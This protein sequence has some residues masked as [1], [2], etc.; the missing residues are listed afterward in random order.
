MV[1]P[2]R[3]AMKNPELFHIMSARFPLFATLLFIP[4]LSVAQTPQ[5]II[6]KAEDTLRG[7][8]S[9]GTFE[10]TVVTPEF[11]R[12]LKMESW[13][14]GE[15]KSL[16]VIEAPKKEEGNKWL[17]IGN[18]MWNYLKS[19]ETTIKIPPSMML[20]SWNGSDFTNDDLVRES[21]MS[22]DYDAEIVDEEETAG[23][24]CWKFRLLPKPE[25]AV[26]WGK[27]YVWVRQKDILP[28][29]VEYYDEKGVLVR[30]IVYD[31]VKTTGGRTIPTTWTMYN[32]VKEG[33]RT[34]FVILDIAFDIA[35][36][37]RVFSFREL[38]RGN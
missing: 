26:V 20:Q 28:S 18:E 11:T 38:E 17:K 33:H 25:A 37:D 22:E 8:T 4:A 29:V 9:R 34:E 15:K 19:T 7:K 5:E 13:W 14:V 16:I 3:D 24:R 30:Y 36:P 1:H 12:T 32:K 27:L 21:S 6:K 31:N 10:M 23:E 2:S 35:I